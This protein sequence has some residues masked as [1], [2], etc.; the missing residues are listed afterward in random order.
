M[1]D[2]E[3]FRRGCC[4]LESMSRAFY[5][6]RA[7]DKYTEGWLVAYDIWKAGAVPSMSVYGCTAAEIDT[8]GGFRQIVEGKENDIF[9]DRSRSFRRGYDDALRMF[10]EA[11]GL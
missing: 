8:D 7:T 6:N 1:H 4:A 2:K 9:T 3:R 5:H 10:R 11:K